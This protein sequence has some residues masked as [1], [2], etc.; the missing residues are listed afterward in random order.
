MIE[1]AH[2]ELVHRSHF[3]ALRAADDDI[4]MDAAFILEHDKM[5]LKMLLRIQCAEAGVATK[6]VADGEDLEALARSDE[7]DVPALKGWRYEVFGK[8]AIAMKSGQVTLG[9]KDNK[10]TRVWLTQ[11]DL[12]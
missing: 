8:A 7:A 5:M 6:L 4:R 1:L 2:V 3:P 9:L 11:E 10:I 12:A